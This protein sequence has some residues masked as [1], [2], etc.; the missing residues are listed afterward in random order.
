VSVPAH[1]RNYTRPG[2]VE[3]RLRVT[4][5]QLLCYV[6]VQYILH[7]Q[8]YDALAALLEVCADLV[9]GVA[10][11]VK[12][13]EEALGPVLAGHDGLEGVDIGAADLVLLLD[14]YRVLDV[15]HLQPSNF[16]I[17]SSSVRTSIGHSFQLCTQQTIRS[18]PIVGCLCFL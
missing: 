18:Q 15:H 13:D 11:E 10:G 7:C 14:L 1:V 4:L 3:L 8:G 2:T 17:S 12:G 6:T 5:C 16:L 9:H